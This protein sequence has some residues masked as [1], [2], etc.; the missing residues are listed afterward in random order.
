MMNLHASRR[1]H[2]AVPNL[3]TAA[4]LT[5]GQ[6]IRDRGELHTI[7]TVE[8]DAPPVRGSVTVTME[9]GGRLVIPSHQ[10]VTVWTE[11]N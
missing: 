11:A 7:D 6:M 8:I 5:P 1:K 9:D 10:D 4:N 2:Q 3:V